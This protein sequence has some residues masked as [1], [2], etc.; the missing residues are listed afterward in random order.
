VEIVRVQL[1]QLIPAPY[2]PRREL[3]PG[4]PEYEALRRSI[5]E[6][7]LVEPLIW[8]R[9]TGRLVGGHQ[10]LRV[11]RDLGV[12]EVEVSVVDL[13]EQRERI[14]NIALNRIQGEWD[15]DRLRG[16]LAELEE[17]GADLSL[18]GF[19]EA[20]IDDLLAELEPA[21]VEETEGNTD[22]DEVP[23]PP[24]EPVTRPGDLWILG[25]HRLLCGDATRE[26]D[27][28]RLTGGRLVDMV[29]TDPP[30]GVAYVGKTTDALT[31][32]NDAVDAGEL[33]DLLRRALGLAARHCRP[34]AG[35]YVAAPPG[36]NFLAFATV[37]SELGIWRQTLIWVKDTFVL[38]HSDY[39]YRHEP[40]FYG[41]VPGD[42]HRTP[43]DRRQDSVWEIPRPKAS[44]DHP[45]MKPVELVTRALLNSSTRGEIVYDPF[46]GSGTT[47]IAAEQTGRTC[48]MMEI[49]PVYCDVAVRRWEEYTGRKAERVPAEEVTRGR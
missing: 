18:T 23:E 17:A 40:L 30:Y 4:D 34:G 26:E 5:T 35:W 38:G 8:N 49:D 27:V 6:F 14:L 37:L 22:P 48:Y 29:W 25:R 19:T 3:R 45:T 44:L 24:A 2:N 10:R 20:E 11:L 31:I 16:L 1:D 36:P 12:R 32:A 47:L 21:E 28:Q 46:G 7:G 43:P 9:R 15:E 33:T 41:W 42:A 13:D 39:H